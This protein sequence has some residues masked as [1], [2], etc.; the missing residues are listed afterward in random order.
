[1]ET[2][3]PIQQFKNEVATNIDNL[4]ADTDFQQLSQQWFSESV[5]RRY[6]YN[7][8]WMGRPIIQHPQDVMAL[9]ELLWQ[10]QPDVVIETG[11]AHGGSLIF[12]ASMMALIHNNTP[13]IK[14]VVGIDIELRAHNRTEIEAH[15]M[16]DR[17]TL[18]E[19]SSTDEAVVQ[20]V[21]DA[22]KPFKKP[23]VILD[24][25]HSHN[26]VLAELNAYHPLVHAGSYLVVFDTV[27]EDLPDGLI[28]DRP[29]HKGNNAKTAVWEFLKS[30]PR[31]ERDK[32]ID[33][34]LQLTAAP[35]GW[36][37]CV[38]NTDGTL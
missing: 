34:K 38:A 17:I 5:K 23:L 8:S 36:L 29:W 28:T 19:G 30:N 22:A 2:P 10:V 15:P 14:R 3:S 21:Y 20:Q 32:A 7:F 25:N 4:A 27:V 18:I 6:S 9:Q 26:H 12:L 11:I 16:M 1:M 13:P 33:A 37:K 31:F 24:S 35:E